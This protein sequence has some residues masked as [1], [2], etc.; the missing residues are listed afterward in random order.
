M[1]L[2][3]KR[4]RILLEETGRLEDYLSSLPGE[5]WSHPSSCERWTVADVVAHLTLLSKN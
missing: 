5:A 2:P 1:L 3:E 4:M